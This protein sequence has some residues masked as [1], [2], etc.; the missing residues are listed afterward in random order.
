MEMARS[1][2]EAE[3]VAKATK[4]LAGGGLGNL[5][6]DVVLASG[7][8]SRVVDVSGNEYVDYLLGSGP[9]LVGHAHPEV[10]AAVQ[11]Q[12]ERGSTFF[13]SNEHAI[14]LAEEICQ[15]MP[16]AEKVRFCSTGTEATLYAMRIARAFRGRDK[17]L[18]F[19]GGYH[20]MHDYALMSMAPPEPAA[21]PRPVAD[22][23]GIPR[24]VAETMLIAPFNDLD[25]AAELITRHRDELAGVI[26]EPLQRLLPPRPGFLAGLRE[27]TARHE[28]PLIFDEVVTSFRL[29]Y[30]G[31]QEYYGVVPDLCALGKAAGG[32]FP[33]TAVAGREALMAH[34]D[35]GQVGRE[36]FLPQI[37]TLSGNPVAT[38]AGL[39]TLRI[40]KRPGTYEGMHAVGNRLKA[41][42]QGLCNRAGI[43]ARVVGE[44]VVFEVFFTDG[45]ITDYRSTLAADR[46]KLARFVRLLR[47]RGVFR[48][49]S[50]FY[51]S[52][53]HD[54]RD[55]EDTVRAF[56]SAL[57]ALRG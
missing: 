53:A 16:C 1:A 32:G 57:D 54:E 8:G 23:A 50:K 51:L 25:R 27:V 42:L 14:L 20:G 30:G 9:M 48:G 24:V 6:D 17:I 18:K 37:G 33:L 35:Q 43:P 7:R 40:L 52:I 13:A 31:A 10:V 41:A 4:Y 55:V 3:L 22:S 29:A 39:A 11:E 44:A 45:E 26:V 28:I 38:A 46:A 2:R 36:G 49:Q 21:F 15:A 56:G 34:F 12:L 5:A 19:E 47:E